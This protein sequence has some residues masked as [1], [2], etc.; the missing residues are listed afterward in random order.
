MPCYSYR[1]LLQDWR[2]AV[3]EDFK[4]S[5][6]DTFP[7]ATGGRQQWGNEMRK[8]S[9]QRGP[10]EEDWSSRSFAISSDNKRMAIAVGNNIHIIDVETWN[11]V[12]I[13]RGHVSE[14]SDVTFKPHDSNILVSSDMGN[15]RGDV[16]MEDTII[17]WEIDKVEG[18]G[19][20]EDGALDG[21]SQAA[22]ALVAE[23]LADVG[24]K[25]RPDG[26]EELQKAFTPAINRVVTKRL[27]ADN[28]RIH[29]RLPTSFQSSIFSPSGKWMVYL[30]GKRPQSNGSAPWD[31]E[32]CSTKDFSSILTLRGHTDAIMWTGW[33]PDET[34]FASVAWDGTNRIWDAHTGKEI[35]RFET[36]KQNWTG[37]FSP[38]SSQ[39]VATDG[40]GIVR[41]YA[42]R[43][44]EPLVW[45]F[46]PEGTQ[47]WRRA[48]AWHPKGRLLAVGGERLGGLL[49]LDVAE[50]KVVQTRTLSVE[51]SQMSD[52]I[53]SNMLHRSVGVNRVKF[54]DGGHKLV[55]WTFGDCSIEVFD[56]TK[57]VK[58]RFARGGTEDGPEAEKWRDEN[59][60]VTSDRGYGMLTW[61]DRPSGELMLA[62]LDFDGIRIWS[63]PLT[64]EA[65][66][67]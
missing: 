48:V 19:I 4:T 39:F 41:V 47:E 38:D 44:E 55:F 53:P 50:K 43:A 22:A 27:V 42:M 5:S 54:A 21:I 52:G 13:L 51:A 45:E 60:K 20:T 14:I 6:G 11:T 57:E 26:L 58:W 17:V 67:N 8:I 33:S 1:Q 56:L 2:Y 30:P 61:E 23:K 29:G 15:R 31:I 24:T 9:F 3:D 36:D 35:H 66:G 28:I 65:Q 16:T 34:I 63:V 10:E 7:F 18:N 32:I 62:S 64:E 49:L 40:L 25:L 12:A 46:K 37:A 59:G